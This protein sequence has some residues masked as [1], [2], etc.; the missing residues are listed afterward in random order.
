MSNDNNEVS[1]N[2][3][4]E[5]DSDGKMIYKKINLLL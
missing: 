4:S 2:S 3:Y 1:R 5:I